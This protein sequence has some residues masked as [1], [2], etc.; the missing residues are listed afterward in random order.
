MDRDDLAVFE[1]NLILEYGST[2]YFYEEAFHSLE[3]VGGRL[4]YK[5]SPEVWIEFSGDSDV[6]HAT[7]ILPFE[8]PD[9]S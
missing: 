1:H 4:V 8:L 3:I 9:W 6:I 5:Y 2:Q 7:A